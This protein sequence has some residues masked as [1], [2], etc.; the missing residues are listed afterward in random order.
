MTGLQNAPAKEFCSHFKMFHEMMP[1]KVQEIL[2]VSSPY[3]AFIMEEDGSLASRIINEYSGLNLSHPPRVTRT[4][5]A[6]DALAVLKDKTIDLVITTPHLDEMDAFSFSLQIKANAPGLPVILL[7]HSPRGVFPLPENRDCSGIDK[8]FI[9]SGNSDLLLALVKNTEDHLN[10]SNDTI[11]AKVRVLVLVEDSPVYYSSFL[12]LIYRE[13]VKQ[14]Q[15]VLG[16]GLNEEHRLLRM[17][18]RPKILLANTYEDALALC[19]RYQ[20]YLLGVISDTRIPKNGRLTEDAGFLLLSKLKKEIPDLPMLLLSAESVNR[21]RAARIPA[22]FLDKNAPDLLSELHD[23]FMDHLGFGDFVFRMPDGKEIARASDLRSLQALL[24]EIPEASLWHHAHRNHFSNWI[25]GRSEIALAS[26]FR[27]VHARDFQDT[28]S[29]RGYIIAGIKEMRK[30]QQ[31][32]VVAQFSKKSFDAR[33][34]DFVK[35]GHGSLGGK[36]RGL[37]FLSALLQQDMSI[38]EKFPGIDIRIP[39]TL[40]IST[41]GFEAFITHNN[42][43]RL[44]GQALPDDV[45]KQLF[46]EAALPDWLVED[47]KTFLGQVEY[48]LSVRSSSLLEDAQFQPYAGLYETYMI[49]NNHRS[50]NRRLDHLLTAVKLVYAST[51]YEGPRAFS[52]ATGNAPQ[53]EAMAVIVQE[54]AGRSYGDFFYPAISGVAQS[55]NFYPIPPMK[56]EEGITHIALG[57]GKTVVEGQKTV[58]FSPRYPSILPQFSVIDDILKNSQHRFYALRIKNYP[59]KLD[60]ET[61]GNLERRRLDDALQEAPVLS[62]S[63][64]YVPDEHRIRDTSTVQGVK[65]LT[66]AQ[67]LKYGSFPLPG[68]LAEILELGRRGMGCPVEIEFSVTLGSKG[69]RKEAFHLLQ[70]RPMVT[71]EGRFE[72]RINPEDIC[73]AFCTSSQALGNGKN[74]EI[75]DIVYVKPDSFKKEATTEMVDEIG[76]VNT[77]L[78]NANRRYLLAG[79]G[80]WGSSDRWLGIPVQWHHISGAGAIIESRD[81]NLKADPS[82]G[83]HFFQ[84]ITS[85]GIFYVTVNEGSDDYLEWSWLDHLPV[86]QEMSYIRHVRLEHPIVIKIDGRSSQCVMVK[87]A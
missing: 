49:P 64:T 19:T 48:P 38:Y 47:L 70:I 27:E 26:R 65:V 53:E 33:I 72:V 15:A 86:V 63:S 79:P 28:E 80:R 61:N 5:S 52:K 60:F 11:N 10:V 37:A 32:G 21:E 8:V 41:D 46:L 51:F 39:Q 81:S 43:R 78:V 73:N 6:R 83:S 54:L 87:P 71:G 85:Q 36:A 75:A 4:A 76:R 57:L 22:I 29:L 1:F 18:S 17:R 34:M 12:P 55:H 7:S 82:Q 69:S 58:R 16:V 59:E 50:L 35:I 62:L 68:V 9:W 45:I 77:S 2:L 44:A 42:L 30:W 24:P 13:I 74:E 25:M 56:P 14:T 3:D 66:F 84:N 40:V 23:F 20:E 31:K 67:V